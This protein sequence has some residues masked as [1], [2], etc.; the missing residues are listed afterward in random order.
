[1]GVVHFLN[2]GRGDCS[3]IQHTSERVSVID[4][5]N[6][7]EEVSV[8]NKREYIAEML[9]GNFRQKEHPANPVQYLKS[10]EIE[11]VFRFILTHPDMDH[12]EGLT[13]LFNSFIVRNFWDTANTKVLESFKSEED[14]KD[15]NR[16]QR[17]RK[18]DNVLRLYDGSEAQYYNQDQ[19]GLG[20]GDY[21]Q[22]LCPTQDLVERANEN[23]EYNNASYVIL[24]NEYGRKILFP[25]DA[26][27]DE[28][29]V[30]LEKHE[31]EL[32][33][34]DVLIAPH[35][36]RKSGGNDEFLDV[37]KPKLTLFGNAKS[38]DLNY[39]A[40]NHRRLCHFTNNEG[41]TFVLAHNNG[42]IDVYCTYEIFARNV[43]TSSSYN[44]RYNAWYIGSI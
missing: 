15:W 27:E 5:C 42:N 41:G 7:R 1:M 40:W 26:E 21:L 28:W 29:D 33:N 12:M 14:K 31:E 17:E 36:G 20:E 39:D 4:I 44:G 18:R 32:Q 9:Q 25:G 13:N 24:Y 43:N 16:Y 38:K 10:L 37:L 19:D 3:I 30:L 34:I 11:D 23:G 22:I 6:G 2:V 8:Q 35:H